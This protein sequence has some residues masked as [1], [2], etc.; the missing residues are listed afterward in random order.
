MRSP[1]SC[2][3]LRVPIRLRL[4]LTCLVAALSGCAYTGNWLHNGFKVGP[5]YHR[6]AAPVA[7]EWI[8]FNDSRVISEQNGVV[9]G[10]WWYVFNDPVIDQLVRTAFDQN[11]PLQTAGL[12]VLEARALR[13]IAVGGLF[14]QRQTMNGAY[15]RIQISNQGNQFGVAPPFR[16]FDFWSTG[17]DA[18]WEL[19]VWG[20]F[21]RDIESADANLDASIEDYDDILVTLIA[22]TAATYV[23]MREFQQRINY[24]RS[25]VE[26]QK[27]SLKIASDRFEGGATSKMDVTQAQSNVGLTDSLIPALESQLRQA[28]NRLCILLGIPP[29][30]LTVELGSGPIPSAPNEVAVGIPAELLRRRPDVRRAERE[31]A[32][33]SAQIGVAAADLFPAFTISGAMNWQA[34]KFGQMFTTGALA[35]NVGPSFNWNLL[36][37]GRIVNNVRVQD[38]RFQQLA[39]TY[40]D[41]VLNANREVEDALIGFMKSQERTAALRLAV[42]A[43]KE[44]VFLAETQYREGATDFNR[45]FVLQS[46]L[47]NQQDSLAVSEAEIALNLIAV[48][49]ALGGGWQI[50]FG[51]NLIPPIDAAVE[52]DLPPQPPEAIDAAEG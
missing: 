22:E 21:R 37:Y 19:D 25:N 43:T 4:V 26:A 11:L 28:N 52:G 40:Q 24:A 41:T 42:E 48:Y 9:D 33:Q 7:E 50:R 16:A 27:G 20:R 2:N 29:R 8:D 5:D 34:Q 49:K 3:T 13:G 51:S 31:V 46:E 10:D 14:P 12:R 30:N 47:A 1:V 15:Q 6:P 38:A 35:G 45:V 32:V 17:F 23:Q 18:A 36:N 44:S 39:V